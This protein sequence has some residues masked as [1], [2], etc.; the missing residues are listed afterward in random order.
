MGNPKF[1]LSQFSQLW[2][3]RLP[4]SS[5]PPHG[6]RTTLQPF[7]HFVAQSC[8]LPNLGMPPSCHTRE[9]LPE[10]LLRSQT[11]TPTSLRAHLHDGRALTRVAKTHTPSRRTKRMPYVHCARLAQPPGAPSP[12]TKCNFLHCALTQERCMRCA[13]PLLYC[14]LES[15]HF[16]LLCEDHKWLLNELPSSA[17]THSPYIS[18]ASGGSGLPSRPPN[19]HTSPQR[20]LCYSRPSLQVWLASKWITPCSNRYINAIAYS[21]SH[22]FISSYRRTPIAAPSHTCRSFVAQ[23]QCALTHLSPACAPSSS[24]TWTHHTLEDVTSSST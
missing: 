19:A 13:P 20:A 7:V 15:A 10:T 6:R 17:P 8:H 1:T 18:I 2:Q 5:T 21:L 22:V 12:N 11:N 24:G 23:P 4:S 9:P 3:T 14:A 16:Y